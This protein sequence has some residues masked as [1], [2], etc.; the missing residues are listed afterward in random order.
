MY[1]LRKVSENQ[2]VVTNFN[3]GSFYILNN[4]P[5]F[6]F[7]N[8]PESEGKLQEEIRMSIKGASGEYFI[9]HSEFACIMTESG[10]T[11]EVLNNPKK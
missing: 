9:S 4:K 6:P 10:E 11:F 1:T 3:L 7:V 8:T 5:E 2:E